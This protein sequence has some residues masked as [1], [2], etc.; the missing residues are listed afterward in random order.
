MFI[1]K[2]YWLLRF[3]KSGQW[4]HKRKLQVDLSG[5]NLKGLD[6][7]AKMLTG[8][9]LRGSNLT[10]VI[11]ESADFKKADL[12]KITASNASFMHAT[13]MDADLSN[14]TIQADFSGAKFAGAKLYEANLSGSSFSKANLQGALFLEDAILYGVTGNGKQI[15]DMDLGNMHVTW[16]AEKV[17]LSVRGES[18][19]KIMLL[20]VSEFL[21]KETVETR[22]STMSI[23]EIVDFREWFSKYYDLTAEIVSKLPAVPCNHESRK[24]E[25]ETLLIVPEGSFANLVAR[26]S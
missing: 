26:S 23:L 11:G 24:D 8:V 2:N 4:N 17:F 5:T 18:E 15:Q 9:N 12:R 21:Q 13:F 10:E 7:S 19:H 16:T 1:T 6:L 22:I 3:L 25:S 14:A 20:D